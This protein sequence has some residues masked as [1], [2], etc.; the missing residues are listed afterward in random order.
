MSR[1][2]PEKLTELLDGHGP[3]LV[4]YAQQF[5]DWPEDVVQET[6]LKLV[7]QDREP[8][9]PVGWLYRAVRNTA[10]SASRSHRRSRRR[11][12]AVAHVE[13][14]WFN[15]A[16]EDRID[17]SVATEMLQSLAIEQRE[18]IVA[19]LWGGMSFDEVARLVGCSTSTAHRRYESGLLALRQRLGVSC[20]LK[21]K[22]L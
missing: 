2:G 18:V 17:A 11:E 1:I 22:S 21:R 8:E 5:C 13:E 4:L 10:I 14:P 19:R 6:F 20:A 12:A 3:A 7:R 15:T 9:N 16:E